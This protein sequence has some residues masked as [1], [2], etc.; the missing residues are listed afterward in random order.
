LIQKK[1]VALLSLINL[2]SALLGIGSSVVMARIYGV[3]TD[4]EVYFAATSLFFMITSLTQTGQLSEIILPIYHRY[5]ENVSQQAANAVFSVV[6]SWMG[7]VA[8]GISLLAFLFSGLLYQILVPGFESSKLE[9]GTS[10][11][12]I[13]SPLI[14][15]EIIKSL[16]VTLVNA[17]KVFAKIE[18]ITLANQ[19][20]AIACILTFHQ[21]F[22][23]YAALSGL[24]LG[25]LISF[26]MA[27][28]FLQRTP[29]RYQFRLK[30][31]GFELKE[32]VSKMSF[33]FVYVLATQF[34]SFGFNAALSFLP[35]GYFAVFKY[36]TL[37]FVKLNGLVLRPVT[38][39][40]FTQFSTLLQQGSTKLKHLVQQANRLTFLLAISAGAFM[41]SS[42]NP[43]LNVL[44]KNGKFESTYI[45]ITFY[46][47]IVMISL[48][49][50]NGLGLIFR[51]MCMSADLVKTQYGYYIILQIVFG[52]FTYFIGQTLGYWPLVLL[53]FLNNVS[54]A[55]IPI[56]VFYCY[57]KELFTLYH[58]EFM[59]K[60]IVFAIALL[61]SAFSIHF[62][63]GYFW[64]TDT[65]FENLLAGSVNTFI[66]SMILLLLMRW[67]RFDE[68]QLLSMVLKKLKLIKSA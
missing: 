68:L 37:I 4:V 32:V 18:L 13:I 29:F 62:G 40:F 33:T 5:K 63:L 36:A 19:A 22:G 51:K 47:L 8:I 67:F 48:V 65:M 20:V 64:P 66:L 57:K 25:E 9:L 55:I 54:I 53:F 3:S 27:F 44:W 52:I 31:P 34:W 35:Q 23:I 38:I 49:F 42:S 24:L 21:Q 10:L 43:L 59:T 41:I 12:A 11:F 60:A 28:Y 1:S 58:R 15:V 39:V 56:I 6:L 50:F 30:T 7:M 45:D 17:E 61:A 2:S 46:T 26:G 14:A 16:L